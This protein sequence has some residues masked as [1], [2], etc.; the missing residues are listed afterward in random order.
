M[1]MSPPGAGSRR[2]LPRS[3]GGGPAKLVEGAATS[4]E[5][6]PAPSTA[7]GGPPPPWLRHRRGSRLHASLLACHSAA[8]RSRRDLLSST[9]PYPSSD[10]LLATASTSL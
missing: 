6:S 10:T 3:G 5:S 1:S 7:F 8:R 4:T 2:P 9:S